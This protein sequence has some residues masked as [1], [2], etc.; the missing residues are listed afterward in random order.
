MLAEASFSG[1]VKTLLIIL[2]I[3]WGLRILLRWAGPY[4]LRFFLKKVGQK[5][6]NQFQ[7]TQEQYSQNPYGQ[8]TYGQQ[9]NSQSHKNTNNTTTKN[10]KTTKQVGEY[11]DYEEI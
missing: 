6:Q 5:M 1:F 11:I 9:N 7:Q 2:L 4:I 3:I 8:N 10:P